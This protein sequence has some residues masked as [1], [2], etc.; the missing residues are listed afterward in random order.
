M[1]TS[2]TSSAEIPVQMPTRYDN[3]TK[4]AL[5]DTFNRR[6]SSSTTKTPVAKDTRLGR[7]DEEI[8]SLS[9]EILGYL[10]HKMAEAQRSKVPPPISPPA[11]LAKEMR[12]AQLREERE[13]FAEERRVSAAV[14]AFHEDHPRQ[15]EDCPL[16]AEPIQINEWSKFAYMPCCHQMTCHGCLQLCAREEG[17]SCPFCKREGSVS[18]ADED[19]LATMITEADGGNKFA[20]LLLFQCTQGIPEFEE[21]RPQ[22]LLKSA[23][24]GYG[25]A[26]FRLGMAYTDG[27]V[28]GIE[29]CPTK[30]RDCLRRS[31]ELGD[32]DGQYNY[33]YALIQEG[34]IRASKQMLTVA[35]ASGSHEQG[36][37]LAQHALGVHYLCTEQDKLGSH[38]RA[39]YWFELAAEHGYRKS[40]LYVALILADSARKRYELHGCPCYA[41][42]AS[43]TRAIKLAREAN[44]ACKEAGDELSV[45]ESNILQDLEA[46]ASS[47]CAFCYVS[48]KKLMACGRCKTSHYCSKECQLSHRKI[49]HKLVC[50]K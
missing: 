29:A 3:D 23:E 9:A 2:P 39:K 14:S 7:I 47:Y 17:K 8:N 21:K 42:D 50:M 30:A 31:A 45:K 33:N 18:L 40:S 38:A 5:Q 16:C 15:T 12:L 26:L 41:G 10:Q 11:I 35:A 28:A 49:G 37:V 22:W 4:R 48:D 27:E 25:R 32:V 19:R 20:Q 6:S 13:T 24:Q 1:T 43:M 46:R 44:E 34:D 36:C